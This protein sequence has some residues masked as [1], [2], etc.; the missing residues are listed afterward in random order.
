M[1]REESGVAE[2]ARVMLTAGEARKR[3]ETHISVKVTAQSA[4]IGRQPI[5]VGEMKNT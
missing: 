1:K 4:G 5:M 2:N 3:H